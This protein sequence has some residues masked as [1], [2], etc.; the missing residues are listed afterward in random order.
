MTDAKVAVAV[1]AVSVASVTDTG[2]ETTRRAVVLQVVSSQVSVAASVVVL[3]VVVPL[4]LLLRFLLPT[5]CSAMLWM[6]AG[7]NGY[8]Y[9]RLVDES[10]GTW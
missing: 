9:D 6:K 1:P 8:G 7:K 2:E 10:G 5:M 4:L 3:D